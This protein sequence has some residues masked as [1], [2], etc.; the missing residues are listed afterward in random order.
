MTLVFLLEERSM[1]VFL[2]MLLPKIIPAGINFITIP[3]EGK[4]DLRKSIPVKL[5]AWNIPETKFIIVQDQDTN[6][7][8]V[9][10]QDLLDLCSN[11]TKEVLVR[12]AC[13]ELEAWYWGDLK[14]IELAYNKD[15]S[16]I[17]RKKAYRIPD[18]I[19][20]PKRELQK[21]LPEH[22]QIAGAKRIAQY[23]D[24]ERNCSTSFRVFVEGVKNLCDKKL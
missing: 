13:H 16:K 17:G 22:Q 1:K 19:V 15:L 14:A 20:S 5:K 4:A 18:E 10:K 3:H 9:L 6:D 21:L 7:C 23:I 12:I 2:D 8:K 24:I 11:C